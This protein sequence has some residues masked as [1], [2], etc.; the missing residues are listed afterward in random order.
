MNERP[1]VLVIHGTWNPPDETVP[2]WHQLGTD[3][4]NFSSQLQEE[5]ARRGMEGAVWRKWSDQPATFSWSGANQHE[6]RIRAGDDLFSKW[7]EIRRQDFSARIHIVAHSHGCNVTLRAVQKY[8]EHLRNQAERLLEKALYKAATMDPNQAVDEAFGQVLGSCKGAAECTEA[9]RT[10][11]RSIIDEAVR[12]RPKPR[13]QT[14]VE[15]GKVQEMD[16]LAHGVDEIV[17]DDDEHIR[18][19]DEARKR[20]VD[21]WVTSRDSNRLGKLVFLGAPIFN[22]IWPGQRWY[23]VRFVL[24]QIINIPVW[25]LLGVLGVY[26]GTLFAW[27]V[28]WLIISPAFRLLGYGAFFTPELNPLEWNVAVQ[29]VSGIYAA[30]TCIAILAEFVTLKRRPLNPYFDYRHVHQSAG[31]LPIETLVVT[32][33]LLDE[34]FL[35]FSIEPLVYG[36]LRPKLREALKRRSLFEGSFFPIG[37]TPDPHD[38]FMVGLRIV[39]TVVARVVLLPLRPFSKLW[40]R[41]LT[42]KLWQL[43]SSVAFGLSPQEFVRAMVT[44]DT[45]IQQPDFFNEHVWSVTKMLVCEGPMREHK[46]EQREALYAFLWDDQGLQTRKAESWLWEQ[47]GLWAKELSA[48]YKRF[49]LANQSED[50]EKRLARACLMLEQRIKEM[51]GI[52]ALTHSSYYTNKQ[53]I[54]G[55][56]DFIASGRLPAQG[57]TRTGA[58]TH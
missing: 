29:I 34:V 10:M 27:G 12:K 52:V 53:V 37:Q 26:L 48:R 36:A 43:L 11:L 49:D 25:C 32:A 55:I 14:F 44:A 35:G 51:V 9:L 24:R 18:L 13:K 41:Y 20:F 19:D 2:R 21:A 47:R 56:A 1:Y 6:D 23:D 58:R 16:D 39:L 38:V 54:E 15:S 3:A 42:F 46:T 28:A 7:L 8:L 50:L 30:V 33:E 4:S 57:L 31:T 5:L 22:K 45:Q 17:P 40:E